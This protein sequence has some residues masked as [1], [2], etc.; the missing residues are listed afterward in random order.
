MCKALEEL[1]KD[2]IEEKV[3]IG[4]KIG[5]ERGKEIGKE[6]GAKRVNELTIML[7]KSGRLEDIVKAAED[8]EYQRKLFEE[9]GL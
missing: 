4:E 8:S 7:S 6:I 1:M 2:K 5:Q 9:Y 3:R